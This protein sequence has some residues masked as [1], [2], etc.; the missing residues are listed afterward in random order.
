MDN[1]EKL[2]GIL[3]LGVIVLGFFGARADMRADEIESIE[4]WQTRGETELTNQQ[5][6][7]QAKPCYDAGLS[8]EEI[9]GGNYTYGEY[10]TGI[11]CTTKDNPD[12]I[13]GKKSNATQV[14]IN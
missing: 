6:I 3:I 9:K 7:D 14:I 13:Q 2:V 10:V 1:S 8:A 4:Y 12:I 5:I 11:R